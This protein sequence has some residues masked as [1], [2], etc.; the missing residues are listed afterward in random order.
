[1]RGLVLGA[2]ML[3][4]LFV[5]TPAANACSHK[6]LFAGPANPVVLPAEELPPQPQRARS[7]V[8]RLG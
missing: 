8:P 2:F 6:S 3:S 4:L 5:A 1:M 7:R